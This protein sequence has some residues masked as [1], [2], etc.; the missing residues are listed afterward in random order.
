VYHSSNILSQNCIISN[1][2][3]TQCVNVVVWTY[4]APTGS[5][6]GDSPLA[7]SV[8]QRTCKPGVPGSKPRRGKQL[9]K[10]VSVT[11]EPTLGPGYF[12]VWFEWLT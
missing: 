12:L 5:G 7:Q 10:P 4:G 2:F 1:A 8:E 9:L 6:G 3:L 11:L